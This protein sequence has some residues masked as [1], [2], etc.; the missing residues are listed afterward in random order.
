[1][2]SDAHRAQCGPGP[3]VTPAFSQRS[4]AC[5]LEVC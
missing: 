3:P 4:Q 1:M 2:M 5:R